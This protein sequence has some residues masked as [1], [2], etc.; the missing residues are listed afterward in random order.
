MTHFSIS[1]RMPEKHVLQG[2]SIPDFYEIRSAE[3]GIEGHQL[4]NMMKN[5]HSSLRLFQHIHQSTGVRGLFG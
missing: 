4:M 3:E 1:F 2:D 5:Y